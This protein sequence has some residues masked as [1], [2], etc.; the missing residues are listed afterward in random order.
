MHKLTNDE[1]RN[2]RIDTPGGSKA[3]VYVILDSIRS[4]YN[5]GS[6][7]RT[8]DGA[9]ITKL[10]LT[11][12][13]P[14]PPRKEIEK[15]ALGSTSTVPWEYVQDPLEAIRS[16]RNAGVKV[17]A[18]ERTTGSM[19]YTAVSPASFPVCLV[20]GNELSG[21]S[22]RVLDRC[23][24]SLEIPMAGLKHSLNVAV[25]YGIAVFELVRVWHEGQTSND[26]V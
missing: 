3:P 21:I 18:L 8:S 10:V 25:A 22:A 6:I 26:L 9:G 13:T 4:L 24:G 14:V 19:L 5:V 17:F 7:F 16:F 1:L 11:G 15:T 12:Y 2:R 20:I 23:D